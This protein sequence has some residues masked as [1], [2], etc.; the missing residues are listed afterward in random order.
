MK[1]LLL[2]PLFCLV[3]CASTVSSRP[4]SYPWM[5]ETRPTE[6]ACTRLGYEIT[7]DDISDVVVR[8][9]WLCPDNGA[10]TITF[11]TVRHKSLV[12]CK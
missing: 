8:A 11:D 4:I 12:V 2:L 5:C 10:S 7:T 3:G 1:K 9:V 6:D